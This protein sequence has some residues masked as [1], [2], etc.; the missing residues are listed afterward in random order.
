M[1]S[2]SA[3]S[4]SPVAGERSK[5]VQSNQLVVSRAHVDFSEAVQVRQ[6]EVDVKRLPLPG[7]ALSSPE[8]FDK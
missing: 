8:P 4:K 6:V 2:R 5:V 1:A 3:K 7:A